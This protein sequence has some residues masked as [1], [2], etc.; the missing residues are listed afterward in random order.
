MT[1]SQWTEYNWN[2][3]WGGKFETIRT[4][5]FHATNYATKTN[6]FAISIDNVC[7]VLKTI[8]IGANNIAFTF[9]KTY[10]FVFLL[11]NDTVRT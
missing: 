8:K 7:K 2:A 6:G 1:L 9:I 10:L 5:T 3:R 11:T 4:Q